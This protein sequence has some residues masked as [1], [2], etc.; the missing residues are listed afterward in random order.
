MIDLHERTSP[1]RRKF[2]SRGTHA[3]VKEAIIA[4]LKS[5]GRALT[6]LEVAAAVDGDV[7]RVQSRLSRYATY[8]WI[9]RE[10]RLRHC[11]PLVTTTYCLWSAAGLVSPTPQAEQE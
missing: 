11:S 9:T 6:T 7:G 1:P 3:P 8:G 10:K 5:A 2:A 4:A